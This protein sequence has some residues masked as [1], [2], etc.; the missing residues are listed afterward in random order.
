VHCRELSL[1]KPF[2]RDAPKNRTSGAEAL[3]DRMFYGTAEPVPF[4]QRVFR[5]Q[6]G[7]ELRGACFFALALGILTLVTFLLFLR[8]VSEEE[9]LSAS[10]SLSPFTGGFP[11]P[12][13]PKISIA[14]GILAW[15]VRARKNAR[16]LRAESFSATATLIS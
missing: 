4:V 3:S 13:R 14:S 10:G 16:V 9:C 8:S 15:R 7:Q 11:F 1:D 12:R 5:S 6:C 2:V